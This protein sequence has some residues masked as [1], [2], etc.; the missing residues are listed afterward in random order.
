MLA[1]VGRRPRGSRPASTR[2]RE[3]RDVPRVIGIAVRLSALA[4]GIGCAGPTYQVTPTGRGTFMIPSP[5]LMGASA[6]STDK[7]KAFE[8][9]GDYCLKLGKEVE[10]VLASEPEGGSSDLATPLI[11]FRCV[12]PVGR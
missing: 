10:T 5:D 1:S 8:D 11:E 9:A 12:P 2:A 3:R 6:G 4:L 7:A